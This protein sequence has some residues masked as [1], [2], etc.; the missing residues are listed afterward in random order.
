[1]REH[2]TW[3]TTTPLSLKS[4]LFLSSRLSFSRH[5]AELKQDKRLC[6][7]QLTPRHH[8]IHAQCASLLAQPRRYEARYVVG[9]AGSVVH[10]GDSRQCGASRP[11][12]ADA[13]A[14]RCDCMGMQCAVWYASMCKLCIVCHARLSSSRHAPPT[15]RT[16]NAT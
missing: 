3:C 7:A 8:P 12:V 10:Q 11:P 5:A 4:S 14:D 16:S 1:L 15:R 2:T 6:S 9:G 13:S